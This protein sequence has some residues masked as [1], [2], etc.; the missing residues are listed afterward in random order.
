[1][2]RLSVLLG[3]PS[4][5]QWESEFGMCLLS[6]VADFSQKFEGYDEQ[7]LIPMAKVGSVLANHREGIAQKALELDCTHV[8]F[9]D[10][11]QTFPPDTLRRLLAWNE[12]IVAC[13]IAT[14]QFPTC[15]TARVFSK[16]NRSGD[17]L[18]TWKDSVGLERVWRIGTGVMLIDTKVFRKVPEP[19]FPQVWI[20]EARK[21]QGEDW[22][23]CERAE[24]FGFHPMIDQ[25]L[26]W[27]IGHVGRMNFKLD[28]V[29]DPKDWGAER[30]EGSIIENIND[31]KM[32][33]RNY[34]Q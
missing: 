12:P 33:G 10:S 15:P 19:W 29:P 14:K 21:F 3:I 23:F 18:M 8:L 20:E 22:G 28:L 31:P 4:L 11:D 16:K 5:G 34:A 32:T 13:N 7:K 30:P 17:L 24:A 25:A 26:S 9:I 1:M 2:K 6:L 27:E